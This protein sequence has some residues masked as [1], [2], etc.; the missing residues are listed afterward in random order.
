MIKPFRYLSFILF[1]VFAQSEE[2]DFEKQ[3]WPILERS[4]LDCHDK[5]KVVDG[6][7][8]KPKGG[9]RIDN[10][11]MIMHGA[12]GDPV[13]IAG[14][15][16]ESSFYYLTI[17]DKDDDDIMPAK[18]PVLTK[19]ETELIK[20]WINQGAKFGSWTGS[21]EKLSDE[22]IKLINQLNEQDYVI[23]PIK[24]NSTHLGV[25]FIRLKS[26]AKDKDLNVLFPIIENITELNLSKSSITNIELLS[27]AKNLEVLKLSHLKKI[28]LSP[29]TDLK[30]LKVL[31][32]YGGSF[33]SLNKIP[34]SLE[35]IYLAQSEINPE[36]V[37]SLQATH[38]NLQIYTDWNRREFRE[39]MK[40]AEINTAT[41]NG[42]I[43]EEKGK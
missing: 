1:G 20:N 24:K 9:L 21:Q 40:K 8:K 31:N 10:P 5:T 18:G 22:Q 12:K 37:K 7:R 41:F 13:I 32:L 33:T 4:C 16:E 35:K 6:K 43:E 15:A 23:Y 26:S 25:D 28:D 3:I 29:L 30:K 42:E 36:E 19:E 2:I 34:S 39:I 38:P 11:E 27:G 14:D 17:L